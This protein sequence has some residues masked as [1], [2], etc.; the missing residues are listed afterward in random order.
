MRSD[1]RTARSIA[2]CLLLVAFATVA[3]CGRDASTPPA[4]RAHA[5]ATGEEAVATLGDARVRASVVP[6]ARIGTAVARQYGIE[7]AADT[8]LLLVGVRTGPEMDETALPAQVAASVQDLRGVSQS[9]ELRRID[10]GELIDYVGT[11]RVAP[12]DSLRFD[13]DVVLEDGRRTRLRFSRDIFP[14]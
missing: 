8:V 14:E 7:P 10:N 5:D 1:T 2:A 3:G 6:T 12:P 4:A 13:V 11:A 9:L